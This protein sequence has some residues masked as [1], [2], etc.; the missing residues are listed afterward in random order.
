M[1]SALAAA[2]AGWIAFIAPDFPQ[3]RSLFREYEARMAPA[4]Q[5]HDLAVRFVPVADDLAVS[6]DPP[7]ASALADKPRLI[8]AP[9]QHIAATALRLSGGVVPVVFSSRVDPVRAGLASSLSRPGKNATGIT[10]DVD[11]TYKQLELLKQLA[12]AARAIGVLADDIWLHEETGPQRLAHYERIF[13]VKV[14]VLVAKSPEDMVALATSDEAGRVEAWLVPITNYSGRARNEVVAAIRKTRKPVVYGRSFFADAGGLAS[15]QEVIS[16]TPAGEIPVRGPRDFEMVL[17]FDEAR[18]LGI[19]IPRAL[20]HR[21]N[22]I[23]GA[24]LSP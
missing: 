13:G 7:V 12:P 3:S 24:P 14:V 16:G 21:A 2:A 1:F 19:A 4:L 8:V 6:L 18:E 10:Y 11:I 15:Y 20:V 23:V 9:A 5:Q 22:R 17:N